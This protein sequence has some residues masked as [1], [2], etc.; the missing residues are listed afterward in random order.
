MVTMFSCPYPVPQFLNA[1]NATSNNSSWR[2]NLSDYGNISVI[3]DYD[4]LLGD[5]NTSAIAEESLYYSIKHYSY[6]ILLPIIFIFGVLGNILNIVI[7]SKN[8]FRH[9]LDEVEK[10]ATAGKGSTVRVYYL[11]A[12][13]KVIW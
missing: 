9:S 5:Y 2:G 8:R 13:L 12:I 6:N 10:S 11:K 7:F 1:L 3:M 4:S